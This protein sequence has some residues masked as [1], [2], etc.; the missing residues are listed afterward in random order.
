MIECAPRAQLYTARYALP[1]TVDEH[2]HSRQKCRTYELRGIRGG[3]PRQNEA[4]P[5]YTV[6]NLAL[7]L[8]I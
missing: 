1:I 2:D 7:H 4:S 5:I 6:S 8:L 3:L